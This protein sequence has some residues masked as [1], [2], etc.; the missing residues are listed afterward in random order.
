M[1][2]TADA[3]WSGTANTI[4]LTASSGRGGQPVAGVSYRIDSGQELTHSAPFSLPAG[5]KHR[6]DYW[7]VNGVGNFSQMKT[8]YVRVDAAT[9]ACAP[10]N[11]I[12]VRR[13]ARGRSSATAS[14][15]GPGL[16]PGPGDG[17]TTRG[18]RLIRSLRGET[19]QTDATYRLVKRL[20]L[21]RGDY[22]WRT[23]AVDAVGNVSARSGPLPLRIR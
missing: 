15:T 3:P 9:P 23:G 19:Q 18:R 14:P 4:T 16:R 20:T 10:L 11:R 21:R 13:G 22:T 1:S 5:G 6:L 7:A 2:D 8:G 17:A 12:V